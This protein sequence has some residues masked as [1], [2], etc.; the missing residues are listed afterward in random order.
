MDK[1]TGRFRCLACGRIWNGDELILDPQAFGK[2]W[3]CRDLCCGA[4][5]VPVDQNKKKEPRDGI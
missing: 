2:K 4:L 5:V 1:P 3:T